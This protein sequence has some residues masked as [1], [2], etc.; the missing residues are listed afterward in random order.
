MHRCALDL[1][2]VKYEYEQQ[3]PRSRFCCWIVLIFG[4]FGDGE[5]AW[6]EVDGS[7]KDARQ[8]AARLASERLL[9]RRGQFPRQENRDRKRDRLLDR[10]EPVAQPQLLLV[11]VEEGVGSRRAR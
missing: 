7:K 10:A 6:S 1:S 3:L 9:A 2:K 11:L 8:D 4:K 5:Y